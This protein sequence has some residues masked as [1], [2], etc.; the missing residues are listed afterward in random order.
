MIT[1]LIKLVNFLTLILLLVQ[2]S[3]NRPDFEN[4]SKGIH[5]LK[6]YHRFLYKNDLVPTEIKN[7]A[8]KMKFYNSLIVASPFVSIIF[9]IKK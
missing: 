8:N 5:L 2:D 3:Y 6:A 9:K 7:E 1:L 4:K